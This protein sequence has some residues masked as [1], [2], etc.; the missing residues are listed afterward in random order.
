M[1]TVAFIPVRG[2]SKSIHLKNIRPLA[3]RPL[4]HWTMSAA[5]GCDRIDRLYVAEGRLS[6]TRTASTEMSEQCR[7]LSKQLMAQEELSLE[8][9]L[10]IWDDINDLPAFKMA[11]FTACPSDASSE[12]KAVAHYI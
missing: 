6:E 7:R 8:A 1:D 12:I 3:G 10:F 4:V 2:G 9:V 11:G 5:L